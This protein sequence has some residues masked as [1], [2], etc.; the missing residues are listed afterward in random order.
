MRNEQQGDTAA[1]WKRFE[2]WAKRFTESA[3]KKPRSNAETIFLADFNWVETIDEHPAARFHDAAEQ[4]LAFM[5]AYLVDMSFDSVEFDN[6]VKKL[7]LPQGRISA[8]KSLGF[9]FA[10]ID[11]NQFGAGSSHH[12]QGSQMPLFATSVQQIDFATVCSIL[13]YDEIV[14]RNPEGN[15]KKSELAKI[16][17]RIKNDLDSEGY[18]TE[19]EAF[20]QGNIAKLYLKE[21]Y[22]GL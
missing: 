8:P 21:P 3:L 16:S 4:K 1:G 11:K 18:G 15:W 13:P 19:I 22:R 14:I 12:F 5:R 10:Q 6:D 2:A 17:R 20:P 9:W 7:L